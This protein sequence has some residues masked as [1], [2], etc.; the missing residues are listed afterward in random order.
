[1]IHKCLKQGVL[2]GMK[3]NVLKKGCII[4]A[5]PRGMRSTIY[6][7][8]KPMR[9]DGVIITQGEGG[10]EYEEEGRHESRNI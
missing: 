3:T 5:A 2:K 9:L 1:M 6:Y 4:K 7:Q 8:R 10:H